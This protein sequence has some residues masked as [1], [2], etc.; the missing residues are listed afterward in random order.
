MLWLLGV[1]GVLF[2][3]GAWATGKVL[4]AFAERLLVL[5]ERKQ[6]F[7]EQRAKSLAPPTMP[8]EL[9]RRITKWQDPVAQE[10]ERATILALYDEFRDQPEPWAFVK[11]H[12]PPE[13]NER[14]ESPLLS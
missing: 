2:A 9:L 3:G 4:A 11:R 12:L 13:P 14:F 8:P 10:S 5:A 6:D 7:V 1:G